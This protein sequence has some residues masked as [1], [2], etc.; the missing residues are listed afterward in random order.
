VKIMSVVGTRPNFM[1]LAPVARELLKR[2]AVEHIIVHTGQHYDPAMSDTFFSDLDIPVPQYH[3]AVGDDAPAVQIGVIMMR[4]DPILERERPDVMMVYGDVNSTVAA[5]LCAAKRNIVIAHVEAGL[6]SRDRTMPEEINRLVTDQLAD[7]LYA[8]SPDAVENLHAEGIPAER[9]HFVGNVMID[10]LLSTLPK[11][12]AADYPGRLGLS[13]IPYVIATLHRPAN[14]DD[15]DRL[16]ELVG[17]LEELSREVA[18]LLPLHPR[19]RRR[20]RELHIV[21][22]GGGVLRVLEP[23][24]YLEMLGLMESAQLVVTDSGGLQEETTFLGVPCLTVRP[25]TERPITVERGTNRL[26]A[27]ERKA[28]VNGARSAIESTRRAAPPAIERWDGRAAQRMV[29]VLC[30]GHRY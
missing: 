4:L 20:M 6:R 13:A 18:V 16:R 29:A 9:I 14:V 30:D 24:S 27:P 12:R 19:T 28:I 25:N 8:P 22:N 1:K 2:G 7:L 10:S 11:A 26:V 17:A 5:A 21:P 23:L 15:P 3:L